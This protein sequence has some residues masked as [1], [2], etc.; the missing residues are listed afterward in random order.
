MYQKGTTQNVVPF[1]SHRQYLGVSG[2]S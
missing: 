1:I 2:T